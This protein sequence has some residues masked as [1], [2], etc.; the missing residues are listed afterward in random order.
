MAAIGNTAARRNNKSFSS[1]NMSYNNRT[2]S[3]NCSK[4]LMAAPGDTAAPVGSLGVTIAR[5]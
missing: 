5:L 1:N 4:D 3:S 2:S